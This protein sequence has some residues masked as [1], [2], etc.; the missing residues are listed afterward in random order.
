MF[1]ELREELEQLRGA[2]ASSRPAARLGVI[3]QRLARAEGEIGPTRLV[4]AVSAVEAL[5][6]SLI[7][8]APGR[9]ASS[10]HFRYRQV[11]LKAPLEL[12]EEALRLYEAGS[13]QDRY[14]EET[15]QL[16]ELADHYRH[17]VVHGCT[18][19]APDRYPAL[20]AAARHVL[21]GLV[22]AGGLPRLVSQQA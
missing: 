21:E 17:L 5:A 2:N 8:H 12:V 19:P 3:R 9:P 1:D 6:R 20:V 13:P 15:W 10:A 18:Y 7:V 22:E 16:F 4:T 11:A 14:G